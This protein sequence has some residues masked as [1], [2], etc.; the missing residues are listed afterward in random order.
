MEAAAMT[1]LFHEDGISFRYPENW[2]LELEKGDGGWA[3][4]VQSPDTAF[5]VLSCDERMP[6]AEEVAEAALEALQEDYPSLEAEPRVESLAGRMAIGH[7]IHFIS[8]DLTNT[9][10]TRCF[11]TEAGTVLMMCQA[12]D[13]EMERNG[14]VLKAICESLAVEV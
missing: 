2:T 14:P 13:L 12:N 6:D 3:A 4:S 7:D 9:C 1:K 8:F 10:W 5:L 11:D